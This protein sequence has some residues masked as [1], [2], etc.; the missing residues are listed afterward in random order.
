MIERIPFMLRLSKAVP[1]VARVAVRGSL[2]SANPS[3]VLSVKEV[4]PVKEPVT[5]DV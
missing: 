2:R 1:K 4:L 3:S 5:I